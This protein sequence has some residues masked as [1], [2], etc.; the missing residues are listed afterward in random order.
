MKLRLC[1]LAVLVAALATACG[2]GLSSKD[3]AKVGGTAVPKARVDALLAQARANYLQ[4]GRRF[5]APGS[6]VYR[7][8]R[9]RATGFLVVTAMYADKAK[10]MGISVSDK[11]VQAAVARRLK[12]YGSTPAR[13]QAAMRSQ[14]ITMDELT[15]EV[16]QSLFQQRVQ[17]KLYSG[18]HITQADIQS[19]Y[20]THQDKYSQPPSRAVREIV[21]HSKQLANRL[22]V[23]LHSGASFLQLVRQY[24]D[25]ATTKAN[26]GKVTIVKGQSSADIDQLVFSLKTG[27][28]SRPLTSADGATRIFQA[29]APAQAAKVTPLSQLSDVIRNDVLAEKRRQVLAQWQLAAK[30]D[31]CS[32]HKIK[33][34]KGYEPAPEDNPCGQNSITPGG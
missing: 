6:S 33:Y 7:V 26:G 19:Y 2:S 27:Q 1:V 12:S 20:R 14:A 34:A 8:F 16:R 4:L 10:S 23:R 15:A 31:Y 22:A 32:D 13:Q 30:R 17:S 28:I 9:E 21:V 5:P 24:S 25:D 11:D 18:I 29:L 3:A